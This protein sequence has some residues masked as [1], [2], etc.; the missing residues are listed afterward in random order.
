[1]SPFHSRR[2]RGF[3]LL[4]VAV[5]FVLVLTA[6][7]ILTQIAFQLADH[8]TLMRQRQIGIETLQN[9]AELLDGS[10]VAPETLEKLVADSLPDGQL[11]LKAVPAENFPEFSQLRI[12][13]SYNEG[14]NRPRRKLSLVRIVSSGTLPTPQMEVSP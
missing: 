7:L 1:M 8:R 6:M 14:R 9:V 3:F 4:D 11:Q 12:T 2:Q 5:G 10:A 13:V